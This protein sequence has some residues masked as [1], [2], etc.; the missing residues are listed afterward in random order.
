MMP[1]EGKG[2][3]VHR[4][5]PF[6]YIFIVTILGTM[7]LALGSTIQHTN[8]TASHKPEDPFIQAVLPDMHNGEPIPATPMASTTAKPAIEVVNNKV[9]TVKVPVLMYHYIR[10]MF[11]KND[12]MGEFLS[13]TPELFE[14]QMAYLKA[15]GY[16]AI[17]PDD[18]YNSLYNHQPLP[19]KPIMIT[20]DDGYQ[21]FL[22]E[23]LRIIDKYDMRATIFVP[24]DLVGKPN[25]LTWEQVRII[26][27]DPR[28]TIAAHTR[29]HVNL[30][31]T[32]DSQKVD[33]E[34]I[35]SR[36]ILERELGRSVS[37]FAYPYGAFSS[38]AIAAVKKAGFKLAFS[39]ITGRV[40]TQN[41]Q[42]II[43]RV[44]V[45]G[46]DDLAKFVAQVRQ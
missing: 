20:V 8:V 16:T 46:V 19:V 2:T 10:Y 34:V 37:Y 5:Q 27:Q 38:T 21:D 6:Y 14:K 43:K 31:Q 26:A 45:R 9:Y 23:G 35:Q 7:S 36:V 11:T 15:E 30:A 17:T 18:L 42:Y 12:P 33:D 13:V 1:F 41:D 40:H 24:T 39:T 25:Y 4:K 3:L 44:T 32:R 22:T 29:H 28:V